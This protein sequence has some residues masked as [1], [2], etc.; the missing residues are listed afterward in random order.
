MVKNNKASIDEVFLRNVAERIPQ[1][2]TATL[3]NITKTLLLQK[4]YFR[5]HPIWRVLEAELF[6][7]KNNLNNE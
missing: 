4:D 6:K 2:L 3:V 7:R 5:E 1:F